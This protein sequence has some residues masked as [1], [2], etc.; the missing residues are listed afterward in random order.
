MDQIYTGP[1]TKWGLVKGSPCRVVGSRGGGKVITTKSGRFVVN[2]KHLEK[3][4]K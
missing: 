3:K 4:D 1:T 2:A